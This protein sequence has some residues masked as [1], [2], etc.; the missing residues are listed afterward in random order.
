MVALAKDDVKAR[1]KDL[2]GWKLDDDEIEK[3]YQFDDFAGAIAFVNKVAELAEAAD[4]H[5]DISIKYNKV[6]L[7]L[8]TH[9][10]GGITEKDF[11]L[12]AQVDDASAADAA[13]DE[14]SD[15]GA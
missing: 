11:A 5:P 9:S 10:E 6:K 13:A 14:T 2:P 7:T 1:V 12:A 15:G 4:H 8:S 3:K